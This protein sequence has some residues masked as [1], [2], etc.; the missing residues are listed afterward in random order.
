M[1]LRAGA[2][3]GIP[4]AMTAH[5]GAKKT[6]ILASA[7]PRR[8]E[9]LRSAGI[10][11]T[12]APVDCD[13]RWF[14]GEAPPAYA[15]RVARAKAELAR[16][17]DATVLAA[18]TTVWL[19]DQV[20][21]LGKPDG[22]A[23]ARSMIERLSGRK[24]FVTTAFAL[25]AE[26]RWLVEAVTTVVW[27]RTLAAAEIEGYLDA[28]DWGDKA[29]GYGIQSRAAGLVRRIE[30]SYTNVVGLPLAEVIEALARF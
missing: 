18:D 12:T 16:R 13:E 25:V 30:G 23:A 10:A 24:H 2:R 15:E 8:A 22:R 11:F 26:E 27:F 29:G 4:R 21:P 7:S 19:E 14:E 6:L 1:R 5:T 20:E 17:A 28:N 3:S 9:L